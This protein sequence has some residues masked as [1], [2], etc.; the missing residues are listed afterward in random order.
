VISPLSTHIKYLDRLE[1]V[2]ECDCDCV[3]KVFFI[4][5]H[6]KIIFFIFLKLFLTSA[7]QNDLK[8]SK[9]INLK[10]NKQNL[11][12]FK[13]ASEMQCQTELLVCV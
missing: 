4:S 9:H 12:F 7:H 13:S 11:N 5:K 1:R 3:F 2:W 8:T 6:I 10:K